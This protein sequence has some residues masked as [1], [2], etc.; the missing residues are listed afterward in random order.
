MLGGSLSPGIRRVVGS[1]L[2]PLEDFY[3]KTLLNITS[4]AILC[5]NIWCT[6]EILEILKCVVCVDHMHWTE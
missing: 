1:I 4:A 6:W 2:V 5:V 3:E